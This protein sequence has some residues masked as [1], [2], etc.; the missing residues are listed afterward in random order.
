MPGFRRRGGRRT[1]GHHAVV[2]AVDVR[3]GGKHLAQHAKAEVA[4]VTARLVDGVGVMLRRQL[5]RCHQV[6]D[7]LTQVGINAL[8][9][10]KAQVQAHAE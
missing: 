5:A 3:F 6:A 10:L 8:V 9:D 4:H 2:I 7:D 1:C